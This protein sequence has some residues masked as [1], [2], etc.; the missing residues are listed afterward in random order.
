MHVY[1]KVIS[2][3]EMATLYL[4]ILSD[5]FFSGKE[6]GKGGHHN[7]MATT[8]RPSHRYI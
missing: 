3:E 8:Q 6:K 5:M 7:N 4:L 1:Y 2:H